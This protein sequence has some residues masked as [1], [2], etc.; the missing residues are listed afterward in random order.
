MH[1]TILPRR[2]AFR[3]GL[4]LS[5]IGAALAG[6]PVT[7]AIAVA[8]TAA[9]TASPSIGEPGVGA[10]QA[11][12]A[13]IR[14]RP[15]SSAENPAPAPTTT[16]V[17]PPVT[18]DIRQPQL[19]AIGTGVGTTIAAPAY[20]PPAPA[21][22][23][24]PLPAA[25]LPSDAPPATRLPRATSRPMELDVAKDPILS[26]ALTTA[27]PEEFRRLVVAAV[28]QHPAL[29][30]NE[31]YTNEARYARDQQ[32][33]QYYP[34]AE[35][36]VPGF[37]VLGRQF[38][39]Q[40]IDNIVERTRAD[41]RF[42]ALATVN[43]LVTD[44]GATANRVKA[45]GSRLRAA[46]YGVDNAADQVA[47]NTVAAWYDVYTLRT[48]VALTD[49]YRTELVRNRAAIAQRIDGGVSAPADAALIENA[50]ANLDIRIARFRQQLASAE[51]RFRELTGSPPP[52]GLMRAPDLGDIPATIDAARDAAATTATTRAA[53]EQALAATRDAKASTRDLLPNISASLNA[54][55]YGLIQ[56]NRDYD[57]VARI[58]LRQRFFGGLPERARSAAAH[59]DAL[60]A[61]ARRI[62]QENARDAETAFSDLGSLEQQ[63]A[64]LEA[65]YIATLRTRDAT[66]ERFR[67]SRGTLFDVL[68]ASD[69]F[70]SAAIGYIQAL[71]QRDAA[72]Y[73]LLSRTGKLLDAFGIPT[74]DT[75]KF[76]Q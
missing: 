62:A 10:L 66:I 30:E 23:Q 4:Y 48:V 54:G 74:Y 39:G 5:A 15:P 59:A 7:P 19:P 2:R 16:V 36:D 45:A 40:S 51:A 75:R 56:S 9:G 11:D 61:R 33:A 41:Q 69:T 38:A 24:L 52:P 13:P 1:V 73:V 20:G 35:V 43:Q 64:A 12:P 14:I 18:T 17:V 72:R 28:D 44:F 22:P 49:S 46:A 53:R 3:A 70:Y 76:D 29:T 55:R 21:G 47:L 42:D 65:S 68:N 37:R 27:S 25:A 58:T 31:A 8:G 63:R 67:Y 60:D 57:V 6:I 26:S 50:V 71:S 32:K 34:S